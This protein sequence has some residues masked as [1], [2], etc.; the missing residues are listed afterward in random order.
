MRNYLKETTI[1]MMANFSTVTMDT[2]HW[3]AI[4]RQLTK[5]ENNCKLRIQY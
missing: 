1:K 2:R 3:K 4:K 5:M